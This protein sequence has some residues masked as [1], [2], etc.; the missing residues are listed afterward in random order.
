MGCHA[1]LSNASVIE[2]RRET[3]VN[4]ELSDLLQALTRKVITDGQK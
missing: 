4:F 2:N 3:R 1:A